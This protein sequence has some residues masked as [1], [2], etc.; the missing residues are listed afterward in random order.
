M[1]YKVGNLK[2]AVN[3]AIRETEIRLIKSCLDQE[4]DRETTCKILGI[5]DTTLRA[6]IKRYRNHL[7]L[8]STWDYREAQKLDS[9][10]LMTYFQEGLKLKEIA[11]LMDCKYYRVRESLI[12]ILGEK[13]YNELKDV[14]RYC[15]REN[16]DVPKEYKLQ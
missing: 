2:N 1:S 4:F 3:K 5:S 8:P 11:E 16:I 13:K 7:K 10:R 15:K 12:E 9:V 14:Y 6:K